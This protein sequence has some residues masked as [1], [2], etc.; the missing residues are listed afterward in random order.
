MAEHLSKNEPAGD[1]PSSSWARGWMTD[2]AQLFASQ[3]LTVLATS[4]AAIMIAR[5]LE[6]GDW[7]IFSAFLGLSIALAFVVDFG[8]GYWLIREFSGMLAEDPSTGTASRIGR[9]VCSGV[10]VNGLVAAPLIAAA[11]V[12]A[13]VSRPGPAVAIALLCLLSYGA[14]TA[15]ANALEAYLRAR[16]RVRLV[17]SASLLEKGALVVLLLAVV[18]ADAG[19]AAIGVAY[20]VAGVSRVAFDGL[21]VFWRQGVPLR[22]PSPRDAVDVARASLPIA[23]NA[24]S[25]HLVPRLDTLVLLAVSTTSAAWFAIGERILGPLLLLPATFSHALYPF[26]ATR[27]ARRASPW[28]IAG[29]LGALGAG[30]AV[31]GFLL[32]PVLIPLLFGDAYTDAVPVAQVMLLVVPI[33]YATGP[34]LVIA[35]SHERERAF[36]VPFLLISLG[37][38]AAIVAG[39]VVGGAT[40]AAAGYVGRSAAILVVVAVVTH[41]AWRRH[42][43]ASSVDSAPQSAPA[44]IQ[45]L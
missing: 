29:A 31:V 5:T 19:L 27:A 33:V 1:S 7:A 14:L 43:V 32:A 42:V 38:T 18:A 21:L 36:L 40:L 9:L 10:L 39:Q 13:A 4:L 24:A 44:T 12:W 16:R 8:L 25:L 26:M 22:A 17:L 28:K 2:S 41:V 3:A 15:G 34:L 20:L 37:G 6:P 35:Y 30:L 11:A 23:F 45:T